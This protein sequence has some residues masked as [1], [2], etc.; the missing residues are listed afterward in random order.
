[1]G[2][3]EK[4]KSNFSKM[5]KENQKAIR[6]LTNDG[7]KDLADLTNATVEALIAS[8]LD[9]MIPVPSSEAAEN[10]V[11]G[12]S[13]L[14]I[15]T[16]YA[17]NVFSMYEFTL[18]YSKTKQTLIVPVSEKD[19]EDIWDANYSGYGPLKDRSN[20]KLVLDKF[21]EKAKKKLANWA[22]E[23]EIPALFVIRIPNLVLFHGDI[24]KNAVSKARFFDL[25]I[26]VVRSGKSMTKLKKKKP[27]EF[28]T[29]SKFVVDSTVRVLKEF[30]VSCAHIPLDRD[31]YDEP[32]DYAKMWVDALTEEQNNLLTRVVFCT[33]EPDELVS[34]NAQL[35]ESMLNKVGFNIV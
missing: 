6:I 5:L 4:E 7:E 11:A 16:A 31:F 12:A 18:K 15:S 2:K 25:V 23:G 24:K 26:E 34:F 17:E 21:P 13:S 27:E 1:M 3:K 35:T 14:C 20:L 10:A 33:P 29:V 32:H 28:A 22:E 19:I 9:G 30:G 8:P